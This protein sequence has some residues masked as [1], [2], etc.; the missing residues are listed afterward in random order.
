MGIPSF[1]LERG[2]ESVKTRGVWILE[3]MARYAGQLLAATKGFS[4]WPRIF[5]GSLS[6]KGPLCIICCC[7]IGLTFVI[8]STWGNQNNYVARLLIKSPLS[9]VTVSQLYWSTRP[10]SCSDPIPDLMCLLQVQ[11]TQMYGHS[12]QGGCGLRQGISMESEN[13]PLQHG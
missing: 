4:H 2:P 5:L 12:G 13:Q 6:K 7:F 1:R 9:S 3:G 8:T 11:Y 10:S